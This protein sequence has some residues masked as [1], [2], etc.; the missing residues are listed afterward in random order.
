M[1]QV[2]AIMQCWSRK[3]P[4]QPYVLSSKLT[5]ELTRLVVALNQLKQLLLTKRLTL[6]AVVKCMLVSCH[7]SN[8]LQQE[9][10][11]HETKVC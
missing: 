6:V 7:I 11:G 1:K 5:G 2:L 10:S 4:P 8:L 3:P 9:V